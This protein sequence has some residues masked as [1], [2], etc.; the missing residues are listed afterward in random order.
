[1]G[2][3]SS[4][5][6][7]RAAS[8]RYA[9]AH[10][11]KVRAW[12]NAWNQAHPEKARE[13]AMQWKKDNPQKY[14]AAGVSYREKNAAKIGAYR[15]IRRAANKRAT[16]TWANEFFIDEAYRLAKLRTRVMGFRWTVDHIVPIQNKIVCGLHV[17]NNLQVIP[18]V[19]NKRKGNR[20]WPDMPHGFY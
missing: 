2:G 6:K 4:K 7:Q 8:A 14:R 16:P 1:M 5:A 10:P 17:H 18:D 12:R 20:Y 3:R 19:E 11:D 13:R 9:K 15:A